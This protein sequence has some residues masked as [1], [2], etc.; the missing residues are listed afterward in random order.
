MSKSWST[1]HGSREV[2]PLAATKDQ[3]VARNTNGTGP[4]T[5]AN[6]DASSGVV[7]LKRNPAW[8]GK[9]DAA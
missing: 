8:W 2:T 6:W 3:Y 5:I 1:E 7:T 9:M 4:F